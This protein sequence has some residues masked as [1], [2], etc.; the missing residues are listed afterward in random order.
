MIFAGGG[1]GGFN[2]SG[3]G[4]FSTSG[5]GFGGNDAGFKE[6]MSN[7]G[8]GATQKTNASLDNTHAA[9]CELKNAGHDAFMVK[10]F[11][12]VPL[13]VRSVEN[14]LRSLL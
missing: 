6:T 14:I 5:G 3:A 8:E 10:E 4:G 13:T 2:E 12:D 7:S 1:G 11:G 9:D